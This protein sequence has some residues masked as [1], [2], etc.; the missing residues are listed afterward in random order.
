MPHVIIKIAS[1][2][3]EEQK[4]QLSDEIVKNVMRVLNVGEEAVSV[5][6]EEVDSQDWAEKVYNPDILGNWDK[7]YQKPGYNPFA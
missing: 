3:S 2:K 1:G 5:A 6:I 7:L 4:I